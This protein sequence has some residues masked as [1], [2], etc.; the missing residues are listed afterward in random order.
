MYLSIPDEVGDG[1]YV[2]SPP[3]S[4][5]H[6]TV[7]VVLSIH[8]YLLHILFTFLAGSPYRVHLLYL[9]RLPCNFYLDVIEQQREQCVI[10]F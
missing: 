1:I 9:L 8:L 3:T 7:T 4:T 6:K 5:F 2:T 10:T